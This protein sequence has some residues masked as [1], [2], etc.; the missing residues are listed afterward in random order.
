MRSTLT[1]TIVLALLALSLAGC[2]GG[3]GKAAAD[4]QAMSSLELYQRA[5]A[6]AH[7]GRLDDAAATLR[8]IPPEAPEA[9]RAHNL[10]GLIHA[11][12]D[13]TSLAR[14]EFE[15][16]VRNDPSLAE[17][18]TN[19]GVVVLDADQL[20]TAETAFRAAIAA[21]HYSTVAHHGLAAVLARSG[22]ID[23]AREELALLAE[24]GGH[25]AAA[26]ADP[27]WLRLHPTDDVAALIAAHEAEAARQ[28][29]EEKR[30]AAAAAAKAKPAVRTVS[31]QLSV[32]PG[33]VLQIALGQPL[34][35]TTARFGQEVTAHVVG[36]VTAGDQV[37]VADGARIQ[38]RITEV[39]RSGR[40]KGRARLGI[41]FQRLETVAGWRDVEVSLIDG[42]LEAE[43]TKK[44]DAA[45]I[46]I[47]A[48][49]GAVLGEVI[50]DNAAAGAAIGGAAGTA[51]VLATKGK[52]IELATGTRLDL[53]LDAPLT[54]VVRTT[55]AVD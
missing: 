33:T 43:G 48:V 19:L 37:V 31:R 50:G 27:D 23:A 8:E 38:G 26:G 36:G 32:P 7:D 39:E 16:A 18:Q 9:A 2:S 40:V 21:D 34:S 29:A 35:T 17:A 13:R 28:A 25:D 1:G 47:G 55:E 6:A 3:E 15:A 24:L 45:K 53:A 44:R 52:E 41:D 20:E 46:G 51:V 42:T 4:G 12:Q 14:L 10:L 54:V 11:R 22:R 30:Q 5:L 49:A